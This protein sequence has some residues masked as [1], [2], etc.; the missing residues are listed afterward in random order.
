MGKPGV[1]AAMNSNI[2]SSTV[3]RER[4]QKQLEMAIT[5]QPVPRKSLVLPAWA[6]GPARAVQRE[7][8]SLLML[9]RALVFQASTTARLKISTWWALGD[10]KRS[11]PQVI[12]KGSLHCLNVLLW[13]FFLLGV[14]VH[15]CTCWALFFQKTNSCRQSLVQLKISICWALKLKYR[16]SIA[17]ISPLPFSHKM[18]GCHFYLTAPGTHY[19]GEWPWMSSTNM[20]K[21]VHLLVSYLPVL[22]TNVT[23]AKDAAHIH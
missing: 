3:T 16:Q 9:T 5:E 6:E 12:K 22:S 2:L 11:L 19:Q 17:V 13:N 18:P 23:S 8:L 1:Q 10:L 7:G 14:L 15:S 4:C 21:A 20:S